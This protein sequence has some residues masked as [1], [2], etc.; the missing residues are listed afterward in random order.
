VMMERT[1]LP[2]EKRCVQCGE[3]RPLEDFHKRSAS[4]DGHQP[5]CKACSKAY[6]QQWL[7]AGGSAL[8][9][10]YHRERRRDPAARA[11]DRGRVAVYRKRHPDRTRA[12]GRVN[13][14]VRDG[15]L[16]R[17]PCEKCGAMETH[18]HHDD[19]SKP[20]EVRWLCRVHH[21]EHHHGRAQS[22]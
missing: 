21:E 17:G 1:R 18:G 7:V 20:L 12:H 5:K 8:V 10:A 6:F 15:R 22:A 2:S 4:K 16:V 19:Y 14:A 3:I 9:R 13:N 11:I